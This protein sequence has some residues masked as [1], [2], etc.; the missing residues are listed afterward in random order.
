[1]AGARAQAWTAIWC[2]ELLPG[3]ACGWGWWEHP[4]LLQSQS[5]E[6]PEVLQGVERPGIEKSSFLV[7][8]AADS[9]ATLGLASVLQG[10]SLFPLQECLPRVGLIPGRKASLVKGRTTA[11]TW[12]RSKA[13]LLDFWKRLPPFS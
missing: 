8:T 5:S 1:M 11:S 7:C 9:V 12:P 10:Y 13:T 2:R 6:V 3:L 4:S